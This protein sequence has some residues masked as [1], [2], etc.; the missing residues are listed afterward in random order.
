MLEIIIKLSKILIRDSDR[1]LYLSNFF[2]LSYHDYLFILDMISKKTKSIKERG[3]LLLYPTELFKIFDKYTNDKFLQNIEKSLYNRKKKELLDKKKIYLLSIYY[4]LNI[5]LRGITN[6][7]D[8][9]YLYGDMNFN[10]LKKIEFEHRRSINFIKKNMFTLYNLKIQ[11]IYHEVNI[12]EK[13]YP[14]KI[15]MLIQYH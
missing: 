7:I 9:M 11:D 3:N 2:N 10:K 12:L 4:L 15:Y 6:D 13:Y 1:V 5:S 8:N 14:M